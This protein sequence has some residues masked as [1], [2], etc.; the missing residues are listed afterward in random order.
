LASWFGCHPF[1]RA[2]PQ[3]KPW[4]DTLARRHQRACCIRATI[5][6]EAGGYSKTIRSPGDRLAHRAFPHTR[7]RGHHWAS[8]GRRVGAL[9]FG[10]YTPDLLTYIDMLG[11]GRGAG[12]EGMGGRVG[13]ES[14]REAEWG[15]P[16]ERVGLG[17]MGGRLP[18]PGAGPHMMPW[19][20][21]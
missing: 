8:Y 9:L 11:W 16:R 1:C 3:L 12:G 19:P 10:P 17:R 4:C 13:A 15:C 20:A 21:P 7:C 18:A 14:G 5:A 2:P 6:S